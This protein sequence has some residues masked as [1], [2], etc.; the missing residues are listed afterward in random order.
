LCEVWFSVAGGH[1]EEWVILEST[2]DADHVDCLEV[3]LRVKF[4]EE[5]AERV[6]KG[7]VPMQA[8][9]TGKDVGCSF[10]GGKAGRTQIRFS[11][12]HAFHVAS[13]RTQ[14]MVPFGGEKFLSVFEGVQC[15]RLRVPVNGIEDPVVPALG[16]HNVIR[17]GRAAGSLS[18]P[19]GHIASDE[20]A[21]DGDGGLRRWDKRDDLGADRPVV[22]VVGCTGISVTVHLGLPRQGFSWSVFIL[23]AF[24]MKTSKL[25]GQAIEDIN[26]T[27]LH[28]LFRGEA[29]ARIRPGAVHGEVDAVDET[30]IVAVEQG[31]NGRGSL[32]EKEVEAQIEEKEARKHAV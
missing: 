23:V 17:Q 21:S 32:N 19:A 11:T 14:V 9:G 27:A 29:M 10:D 30:L 22:K 28:I 3:G 16:G 20:N 8:F 24:D 7:H 4:R 15:F 5:L 18:Q 31:F 12:A 25:D 1:G 2:L 26:N 6:E 13:S